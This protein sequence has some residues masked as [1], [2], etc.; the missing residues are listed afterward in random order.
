[1]Q[2]ATADSAFATDFSF[3]PNFVP[4][5]TLEHLKNCGKNTKKTGDAIVE[6]ASSKGLRMLPFV[7]DLQ[8]TKG[9]SEDH[10]IYHRALCWASY[11]KSVKY[12]VKMVVQR[13]RKPKNV[14]SDE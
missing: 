9:T 3:L 12:K 2:P 11:R 8:A 1:M 7:H 4:T 5:D 10:V 6:F 14:I 13:N